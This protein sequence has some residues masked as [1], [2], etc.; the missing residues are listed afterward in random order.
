MGRRD[1]LDNASQGCPEPI[2]VG[3]EWAAHRRDVVNDD[4]G[5]EQEMGEGARK[6]NPSHHCCRQHDGDEPEGTGVSPKSMSTTWST[7]T[8]R[9]GARNGIAT[10]ASRGGGGEERQSKEQ[11]R[12]KGSQK[13]GKDGEGGGRFGGPCQTCGGL[14]FTGSAPRHQLERVEEPPSRHVSRIVGCLV[15]CLARGVRDS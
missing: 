11:K 10:M 8:S 1:A 6:E 12:T 4:H 7:R 15:N 3:R 5:F 14:L 2:C 13:D 9:S